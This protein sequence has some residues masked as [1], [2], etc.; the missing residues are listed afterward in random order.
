ERGTGQLFAEGRRGTDFRG[1]PGGGGRKRASGSGGTGGKHAEQADAFA[2]FA[3]ASRLRH[4]GGAAFPRRRV[5]RSGKPVPENFDG[6]PA[7][8]ARPEESGGG[9]AAP[10]RLRGGGGESE[11]GAGLRLRQRP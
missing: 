11:E 9:A 10:R 5:R 2:A 4:G 7:E 3:R 8:H 6:P 1:G